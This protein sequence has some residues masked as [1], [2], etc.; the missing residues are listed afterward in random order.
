MTLT[1]NAA[2]VSAGDSVVAQ[3]RELGPLLAAN[4]TSAETS[5]RVSQET[6]EALK[7]AGAFRISV[8]RRYGGLETSMRTMLDVSAAIAEFDGGASWVAALS[9]HVAWTAALGPRQ[10]HDEIWADGPDTIIAGVLAPGGHARK[11][12]GGFRLSARWPYAS[13]SLHAD[14]MSGGVF[15]V[16]DEDQ[17]LEQG[18]V[19][20]PRADFHVEDTWYVAGMRGSGSNTIVVDDVFVPEHRF[21]SVL[22]FITGEYIADHP[23]APFYR[24]ALGPTFVLAIVGPQLGL[25]RAALDIVRHKG[26]TKALAYTTFDQNRDSVAFQMLLAEAALLIDSAHL[27]AYRGTDD[28]E[29]YADQAVFPDVVARARMRADAAVAVRYITEAINTLLN[30]NGAGSFA[31]VNALQR[32]WRDSSVAARHAVM[33]PQ[34]SIET[35]GKALVG[36]D[37]HITPLL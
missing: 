22:P 33:L 32:I 11:V 12:P 14:W 8:P 19:L 26:A 18:T 36:I 28:V 6:I 24:S 37:E 10:T 17:I 35:Y 4:S 2:A 13:G 5:R 31:E 1:T 7:D 20:I 21:M 3:I 23:D 30:A 27:H 16:D 29:R 34:V 15:V 25:G 9:N